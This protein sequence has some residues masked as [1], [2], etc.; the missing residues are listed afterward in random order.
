MTEAMSTGFNGSP[1]TFS[2]P[3]PTLPLPPSSAQIYILPDSSLP[4]ASKLHSYLS[5]SAYKSTSKFRSSPPHHTDPSTFDYAK[6]L[7]LDLSSPTS[8]SP[9]ISTKFIHLIARFEVS[10]L[11]KSLL[12]PSFLHS[13]LVRRNIHPLVTFA[14]L[15][16]LITAVCKSVWSRNKR[17]VL[18]LI[19]VISP[20][21]STVKLLLDERSPTQIDAT[22]PTHPTPNPDHAIPF[23]SSLSKCQNNDSI[24]SSTSSSTYHMQPLLVESKVK[25]WRISEA[26]NSL[27]AYWLSYGS[28]KLIGMYPSTFNPHLP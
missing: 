2:S 21:I 8:S 25:L 7:R 3:L 17:M 15:A 27:L 4:L 10:L 20:L 9:S 6:T 11:R 19:G 22:L 23:P 5:N 13:F 24:P 28:L 12:L 18:E 1:R 14:L 16:L 26:K